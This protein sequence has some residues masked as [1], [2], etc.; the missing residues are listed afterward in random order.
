[1]LVKFKIYSKEYISKNAKLSNILH[2]RIFD[3]QTSNIKYK[4]FITVT[5]CIANDK[6]YKLFLKES[7]KFNFIYVTKC[8]RMK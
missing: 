5:N 6:S 1:M 7:K 3:R 8:K 4:K 2:N